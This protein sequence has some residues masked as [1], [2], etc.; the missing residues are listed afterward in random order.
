MSARVLSQTNLLKEVRRLHR[1]G[2]RIVTTNGSFDLLHIGHV[3]FL[4][5]TSQLGDALIVLLNSD[6][7][8]RKLKGPTRPILPQRIRAEMMAALRC[9][10]HVTIFNEDTP[11]KLLRKIKPDVH[12][13]G[14]SWQPD[15]IAVEKKLVE[16]WG[17]RL[18]LFPMIG[19]LSTTKLIERIQSRS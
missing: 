3:R 12:S 13:K 6:A 16:S 4:Q 7:S 9:V 11:L 17:G 15:R 18:R 19:D 14:G 1:D 5:Q 8:I 10:D 2:K